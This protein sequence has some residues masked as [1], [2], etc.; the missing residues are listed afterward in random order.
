MYKNHEPDHQNLYMTVD[1]TWRFMKKSKPTLARMRMQGIG[2]KFI[3]N[4]RG[5]MYNKKDVIDW[6]EGNK[7]QST[8]EYSSKKS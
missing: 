7:C 1:E 3:K 6:L 8:S 2:P 5:V 4:G